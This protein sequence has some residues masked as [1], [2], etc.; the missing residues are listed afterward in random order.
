MRL[1][2]Q[3]DLFSSHGALAIDTTFATAQRVALD[4]HSWVELVPAWMT[5]SMDLF[6]HLATAVPWR[7]HYRRLFEQEFLEP[8]LTAEY[9]TLHEVPHRM[10]IAAAAALSSRYDVSY[11]SLWLNLYRNGQDSTGW[12]RDRFSCR[13]RECIVPVLTLGATRR[14]LL[15]PHAGGASIA[16]TPRSGDLIVMGGACQQEWLHA[17]PKLADVLAPRISLN[18][19]SSRQA[20]RENRSQASAEERK[21]S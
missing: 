5:G 17:V 16:F 3:D 10:I 8:R 14:F 20:H 11:D 15:K 19:Q 13:R 1:H 6:E 18:F 4:T 9:R 2:T 12:H 21:P 7:Q